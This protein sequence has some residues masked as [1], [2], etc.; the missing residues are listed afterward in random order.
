[1][2]GL[3][4]DD[5]RTPRRARRRGHSIV[6]CTSAK[7]GCPASVISQSGAQS[8]VTSPGSDNF[9]SIIASTSSA[10]WCTT[11]DFAS[12]N[13]CNPDYNVHELS[14]VDCPKENPVLMT[15]RVLGGC[16]KGAVTGGAAG[17]PEGFL[18]GATYSCGFGAIS[19]VTLDYNSIEDY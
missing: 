19:E 8:G 14:G 7:G 4:P 1:M 13:A 6:A 11:R 16:L 18:I 17:E 2:L 12:S 3:V 5:S 10:S 9:C 15:A